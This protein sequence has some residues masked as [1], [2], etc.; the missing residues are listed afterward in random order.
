MVYGAIKTIPQKIA[1]KNEAAKHFNFAIKSLNLC[2]ELGDK[3]TVLIYGDEVYYV[4][5]AIYVEGCLRTPQYRKVWDKCILNNTF[6]PSQNSAF[7]LF[8]A[9]AESI[10]NKKSVSNI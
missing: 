10:I 8:K 5:A 3:K 7:N 2:Y 9:N 4:V 1:N 6:N